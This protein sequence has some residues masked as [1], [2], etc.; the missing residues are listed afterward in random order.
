MLSNCFLSTLTL[1]SDYWLIQINCKWAMKRTLAIF[2]VYRGFYYPIIWG[3]FYKQDPVITQ[4]GFHGKNSFRVFRCYARCWKSS[5]PWKFP[6]S[7]P[8]MSQQWLWW[9]HLRRWWCST[10]RFFVVVVVVV[11][12]FFLGGVVFIFGVGAEGRFMIIPESSR[13]LLLFYYFV[14]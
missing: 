2:I 4:P 3:L 7:I 13:N 8:P 6:S 12:C 9:C 10:I 11:A 1:V 14:C 5:R